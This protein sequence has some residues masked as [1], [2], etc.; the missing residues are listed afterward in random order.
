MKDLKLMKEIFNI[1][2]VSTHEKEVKSFLEKHI[3]ADRVIYDNIGGVVFAFDGKKKGENLLILA[4]MDEVGFV[5]KNICENGIIK[6]SPIGGHLP[7]VTLSQRV[8]LKLLNN[9]LLEGVILGKSPHGNETSKISIEDLELDFGFD[10]KKEAIKKGVQKGDPITYK[11]DMAQLENNKIVT[12]SA[13][14]RLGCLSLIEIAKKINK[15]RDFAGTLYLGASVQEELGLRGAQTI[16]NSIDNDID[17][18]L[19]IDVSPVQDTKDKENG[20]LGGGTLIRVKDPRCIL[21][22]EQVN[23]LRK[24]ATD[25]KIKY[26]DFFSKGGTDAAQVQ[27]TNKGVVTTALCVPARNLHSNNTVFKLDDFNATNELALKYIYKIL[28]FKK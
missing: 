13:D 23:V 17:K 8:N 12:K 27:I 15:N 3:K 10:S 14:N 5:V 18:A 21:D 2:A 4:H 26:E 22:Y 9:T 11:N 20:F 7:E 24:L 16:V 6:V 28:K 1:H 19:I 25:N